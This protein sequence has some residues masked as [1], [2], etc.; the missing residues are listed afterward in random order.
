MNIYKY[1]PLEIW[2]IIFDFSDFQT[3]IRMTLVCKRF[4]KNFQV[5]DFL[6]IPKQLIKKL[7]D[8]ILKNYKHIQFLN[9]SDNPNVKNVNWITNLKI[10]WARNKCGINQE[11][12]KGLNLIELCITNNKSISNVSWMINLK[13]LEAGGESSLW[14]YGLGK[15]D[16]VQLDVCNNQSIIHVAWMTNLRKLNAGWNSGIRQLGI[17]GLKLTELDIYG[18]Q[19]I[20]DVSGMTTLKKL[21]IGNCCGVGPDGILGLDLYELNACRNYKIHGK[22]LMGMSNL[23]KLCICAKRGITSKTSKGLKLKELTIV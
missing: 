17:Q 15:L 11:G 19:K 13:K 16:L 18:N 9:A 4:H 20:T 7:N 21:S 5:I 12:I 2:K 14:Q 10:L 23:T 6:N 1:I 8:D 3:Q 22:D